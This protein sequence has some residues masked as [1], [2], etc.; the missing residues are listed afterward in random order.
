MLK[1]AA[2]L[3]YL[4]SWI[5][6]AI[7]ALMGAWPRL[8]RQ[9]AVPVTITA[10]VLIGSLLQVLAALAMTRLMPSGPLHPGTFELAGALV[11]APFG[12]AF[13]AWALHSVPKDVGEGTLVTG[14]AYAWMR[15]PIYLAFLA[16]LVAT[17]FLI[18][19]GV[20]M[21]LPVLLYIGGSELRIASEENELAQK[22]PEGYAQYRSRTR[23]RYLPGLR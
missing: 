15:H 19:G 20:K 8:R 11:V 16:M 1:I 3:A 23:W 18:S 21:I 14:G 2:Y 10:P 9:A 12:A 17:G 6:F 13:F 22:F 7:A 4:A 5:A